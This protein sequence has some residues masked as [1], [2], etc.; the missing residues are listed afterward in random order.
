MNGWSSVH[1]NV[2]SKAI[3]VTTEH[4]PRH[5]HGQSRQSNRVQGILSS[6]T[7]AVLCRAFSIALFYLRAFAVAFFAPNIRNRIAAK[8]PKSRSRIVVYLENKNVSL[9]Y[10]KLLSWAL[11]FFVSTT[12]APTTR[13]ARNGPYFTSYCGLGDLTCWFR[14]CYELVFKNTENFGC[15]TSL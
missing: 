14:V 6:V 10:K 4:R 1:R 7:V 8:H 13:F 2:P 15:S 9:V 11:L 12:N 3:G 5:D